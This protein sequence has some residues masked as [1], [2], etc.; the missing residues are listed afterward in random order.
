MD[1][2]ENTAQETAQEAPVQPVA[3][4][5]PEPTPEPATPTVEAPAPPQHPVFQH[6]EDFFFELRTNVGPRVETET[7][8][9][10][11]RA[12]DAFKAKVTA[13]FKEV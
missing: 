12:A 4:P 1:N 10:I 5:A 6:I 8:N 11:T 9:V 7:W 3:E 13:L 2:T